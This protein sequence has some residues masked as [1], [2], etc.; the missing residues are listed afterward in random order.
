LHDLVKGV[1]GDEE[2]RDRTYYILAFVDVNE[3]GKKKC[4]KRKAEEEREMCAYSTLA[5]DS[6]WPFFSGFSNTQGRPLS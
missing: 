4:E 5:V 6:S 2:E 1:R 3:A